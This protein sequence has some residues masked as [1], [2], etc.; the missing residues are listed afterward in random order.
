MP[1]RCAASATGDALS[2]DRDMRAESPYEVL[3]VLRTAP[4]EEL[5]EAYLQLVKELHPDTGTAKEADAAISDERF[6][7]VQAAWYVIGDPKRRKEFDEHGTLS[8]PPFKMSQKMWARLRTSKPEE[9]VVMPNWGTEEPP[10]W[11]IVAG[12][13]SVLFLAILFSARWDIYNMIYD[14]QRMKAGAWPCEKCLVIN[15][16]ELSVCKACGAARVIRQADDR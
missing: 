14:S 5:R 8:A 6:K 15:E 12:P 16:A 2:A 4:Q 11:L 1:R 9:G 13:F 3:G 10:K 7:E